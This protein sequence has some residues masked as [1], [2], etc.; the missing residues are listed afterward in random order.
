MT[1]QIALVLGATG[2][3]GGAV[4]RKLSARGW[5]VR[6][7]NRNA[8]KARAAEPCLNW[9]Q[10]DAMR[11]A[12]VMA[13]AKGASLIV[14]AVNPPGYRDW[15]KLVLPMLD[16]TIASAKAVGATVVLPGTVYNFGPDAFPVL[17]EDSPQHPLT[18]KGGIRVEMERRLEAGSRDGAPVIIVRAGDFFGP[19]AGSSWFSQGMITPDKPVSTVTNPAR[20]GWGI[21]GPICP[22]SR[23]PWCNWSSAATGCLSSPSIIWTASGI[24]T[25]KRWSRRSGAPLAG[26]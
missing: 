24:V 10:G 8:E 4:A 7:L 2:G 18:R 13:A 1:Q 14:H 21:S 11:A 22:M 9:V 15:E 20:K 16:N 26:E 12:D 5:H 23:K 3:I 19:G 25:G 6:A 17:R